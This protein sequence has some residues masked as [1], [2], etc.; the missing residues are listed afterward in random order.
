[1]VVCIV[2]KT[3]TF[4]IELKTQTILTADI[5]QSI[6]FN[7]DKQSATKVRNEEGNVETVFR[8]K[9]KDLFH[10]P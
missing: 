7:D 6:L 3:K 10:M 4:G 9:K 5:I 8:L 2:T 1:M